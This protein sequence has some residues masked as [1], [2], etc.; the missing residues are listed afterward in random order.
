VP[1]T[2]D[3]CDHAD[4]T[5]L[6]VGGQ[7]RAHTRRSPGVANAKRRV[8]KLELVHFDLHRRPS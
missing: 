2:I 4:W 5:L 1:L 6:T 8:A 3:G 7:A